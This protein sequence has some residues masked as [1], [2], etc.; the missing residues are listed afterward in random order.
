MAIQ[1]HLIMMYVL[2]HAKF[3]NHVYI[4]TT[5]C[6]RNADFVW[7]SVTV[8]F[9][10]VSRTPPPSPRIPCHLIHCIVRVLNAA[11]VLNIC[12]GGQAQR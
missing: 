9:S 10:R 2:I 8:D 12:L 3:I 5:F 1:L 11:K 6:E 7:Q 4:I